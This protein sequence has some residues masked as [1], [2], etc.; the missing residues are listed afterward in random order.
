MLLH[1]ALA[2]VSV[3]GTAFA[4]ILVDGVLRWVFDRSLALDTTILALVIW[5]AIAL[6][7]IGSP[8]QERVGAQ[9]EAFPVINAAWLAAL[10]AGSLVLAGAAWKL[11]HW[12]P[13]AVQL[14]VW[15]GLALIPIGFAAS[16]LYSHAEP[17][18]GPHANA[19]VRWPALRSRLHV[20][21]G[22]IFRSLDL[23]GWYDTAPRSG[24]P[25]R[26]ADALGAVMWLAVWA[27]GIYVLARSTL[28]G[29]LLEFLKG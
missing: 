16:A 29:L 3:V 26:L 13:A 7:G 23:F 5:S 25:L 9:R 24:W 15:I 1:L 11:S 18:E 19:S 17:K 21:W 14:L 2:V 4:L 12:H 8:S 27:Y 10:C 22:S 20:L 6:N 28:W